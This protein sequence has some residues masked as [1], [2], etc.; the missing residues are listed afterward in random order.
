MQLAHAIPEMV[1]QQMP[2][3]VLTRRLLCLPAEKHL[4]LE[5]A[6]PLLHKA[7]LND[8]LH[9]KQPL[10]DATP[11][12]TETTFQAQAQPLSKH[13]GSAQTAHR[14]SLVEDVRQASE[15]FSQM[16]SCTCPPVPSLTSLAYH[17]QQQ[18]T[19]ST[20]TGSTV[21]VLH[22][23]RLCFWLSKCAACHQPTSDHETCQ[24]C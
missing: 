18:I 5:S 1:A 17:Q 24:T 2:L 20:H 21:F 6:A 16:V 3:G 8:M 13:T 15:H 12:S 9:E 19:W 10:A 23:L 4:L 22:T 14:L 11:H 7:E